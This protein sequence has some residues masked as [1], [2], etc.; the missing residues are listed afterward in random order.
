MDDYVAAYWHNLTM[1]A[2]EPADRIT[3]NFGEFLAA[4]FNIGGLPGLG[5][6]AR[7]VRPATGTEV[8][9]RTTLR[10]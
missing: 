9:G 3:A 7:E 8:R 10:R 1:P 2:P 6:T 4:G 5:G